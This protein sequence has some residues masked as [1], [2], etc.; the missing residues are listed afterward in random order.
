[1]LLELWFNMIDFSFFYKYSIRQIL[2]NKIYIDNTYSLPN[3][4][5]IILFFSLVNIEDRDIV[6]IYNYVYLFRF[7]FGRNAFLTRYKSFF[8]LGK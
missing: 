8:N 4:K 1:M 5:K 7:F 3:I 2:I 6:Q